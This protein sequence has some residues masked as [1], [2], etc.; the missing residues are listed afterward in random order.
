[1][2]RLVERLVHLWLD[3]DDPGRSRDRLLVLGDPRVHVGHVGVARAVEVASVGQVDRR[4][5]LAGGEDLVAHVLG[6]PRHVL[7][8]V[9]G[10]L[11]LLGRFRRGLDLVE[12]GA[13]LVE[14]ATHRRLAV[15]HGVEQL[16]GGRTVAAALGPG[17]AG[18]GARDEHGTDGREQRPVVSQV[19]HWFILT[20][21]SRGARGDRCDPVRSYRIFRYKSP[22]I[23]RGGPDRAPLRHRREPDRARSTAPPRADRPGTRC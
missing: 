23:T 1:G 18:P 11:L 22:G 17:D 4:G 5:L 14:V 8:E 19:E 20:R 3:L 16:V 15:L 9:G 21:T 10:E 12:P 7:H 2:H 13:H 6:D